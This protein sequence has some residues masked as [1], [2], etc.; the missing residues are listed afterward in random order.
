G[1]SVTSFRIGVQR[2]F[3]KEGSQQT[4]DFINIVCW[5]QQ[6]E[7]VTRYFTKGKPILIC[8][9]LQSRSYTDKDGNPKTVYEVVADEVSFVERKQDGSSAQNSQ[10]QN[11]A[12]SYSTPHPDSSFED[13]SSDDTLPF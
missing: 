2:R 6:A 5:R 8:G 12:P 1:L 3:V 10:Q 13:I 4:S 9:S 7:F 11:A